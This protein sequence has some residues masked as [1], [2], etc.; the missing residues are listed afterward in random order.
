MPAATKYTSAIRA[1]EAIGADLYNS[2]GE[3]I[4]KIEDIILE[5]TSNRTMFAVVSVGGAVT[6]SDNHYAMP[7]SVLDYKEDRGGY[8]APCTKD[9]ILKGPVVSMISL[10]D[11][12]GGASRIAAY[13]HYKVVKDW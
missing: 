6:T 10:T 4:G 5:N 2:T 13:S 12:D 3:K 11:S 1:S 7:W 8:V 9:Q